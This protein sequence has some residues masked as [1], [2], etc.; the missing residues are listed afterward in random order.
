VPVVVLD[1]PASPPLALCDLKR[2]RAGVPALLLAGVCACGR[3]ASVGGGPDS[4]LNVLLLTI[5]TLRADHLSAYGYP[6]RTSPRIDAL[7]GDG[8]LFE[9]AFTYWPK[10]RG[11]FAV[12]HTG[13]F[14]SQNGFDPARFPL[15]ASFNAT[16]ATLLKSVGY[17]TRGAVDNPNV[18]AAL[19]FAR[20]FDRYRETWQE[21]DLAT[22]MD[23]THAITEEG[24]RALRDA[25]PGQPFFLWL[26]YVNP[27]A[28]YAPPAPFDTRFLDSAAVTGPRLPVS[29]SFRGGIP[30][31]LLVS[32]HR[33]L[34][35]YVAQY[36]GEIA[37]VDEQVGLVL[38][39][40]DA[41]S[42]AASTLVI[43][44][45]DHGESLGEHGYYF[46]HGEDM[47]DPSLAVPLIIA[48]PGAASRRTDSF[49]WTLDI[50]PTILE[51]AG[52]PRPPDLPGQS[53]FPL[54]GGGEAPRRERLF[55]QNDDG[56]AATWNASYKLVATPRGSGAPAYALYDR[57]RDSAE[58]RD[59]S[60]EEPAALRAWRNELE[61]FFQAR[62]AEWG[63]TRRATAAQPGAPQ[64][65]P[66]ACE[67]LRGLGYVGGCAS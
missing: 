13:R 34:G 66:E 45:S 11:S 43:L 38:D 5:D 28:P 1:E 19:G 39:A 64:L 58:S 51:A 33:K 35:W 67:R 9:R 40:L 65:T 59:V 50:L 42:V 17:A 20:G 16:I 46:D 27:H 62:G 54:L 41:S 7:A 49:A 12:L 8:V 63:L 36:D 25:R 56:L 3:A 4:R 6:R 26:H 21:R 22:E 10:T 61:A 52:V 30:Q 31:H 24:I 18:G 44:T 60:A 14:P 47:F 32:R 2:L 53:L 57:A 23:R 15:M 29:A 37:A 55:A 48:L